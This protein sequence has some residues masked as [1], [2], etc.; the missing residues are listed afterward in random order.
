MLMKAQHENVMGQFNQMRQHAQTF[1]QT[2]QQLA[3]RQK[4]EA[5]EH[6]IAKLTKVWP[7]FK[8]DQARNGFVSAMQKHYGY[9]FDELDASMTDHRNALVA[10]DAIKWREQEAKQTKAKVT[11]KEKVMA[12]KPAK[13]G[14]SQAS[15]R[16]LTSDQSGYMNA[17]KALK[18]NP[19]DMHAAAKGFMRFL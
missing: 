5:E 6:E 9:S 11:L 14:T 16:T 17:R 8:D 2:Q 15:G 1:L 12:A 7:E 3:E 18:S 4:T 10:R 13:A 19:K